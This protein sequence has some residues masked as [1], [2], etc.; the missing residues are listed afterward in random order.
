MENNH[1]TN[2]IFIVLQFSRM[3]ALDQDLVWDSSQNAG[4]AVAI[5]V[6]LG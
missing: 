4:A 3:G 5:P 2:K 1:K 6:I